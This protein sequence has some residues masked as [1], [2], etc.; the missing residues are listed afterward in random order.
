MKIIASGAN[1]GKTTKV[2]E[3]VAQHTQQGKSVY[4]TTGEL[5]QEEVARFLEEKGANLN[6][7]KSGYVECAIDVISLINSDKESDVVVVDF[8]SFDNI[9]G[10]T[11]L[12][13]M[14]NGLEMFR[15]AEKN[16]GKEIYLTVQK[17]SGSK[18]LELEIL[19]H[20]EFL[21]VR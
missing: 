12:E 6:L 10:G 5:V 20:E 15:M 9:A 13:K 21:R 8:V 7:V 2:M 16:S 18:S 11:A 3:L 17:N 14:L 1:R 19:E 4:I